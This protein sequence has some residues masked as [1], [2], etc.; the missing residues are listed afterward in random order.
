MEN[1]INLVD[2]KKFLFFYHK[3]T[4]LA[5][6]NFLLGTS[7]FFPFLD[8]SPLL[9]LSL[10]RSLSRSLSLSLSRSLSLSNS[11][12]LILSLSAGLEMEWSP[13]FHGASL[14]RLPSEKQPFSFFKIRKMSQVKKETVYYID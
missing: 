14:D 9:F 5:S 2:R 13:S 12:C 6:S 4:F 10:S 11:L 1:S 3:N 7:I 8:F